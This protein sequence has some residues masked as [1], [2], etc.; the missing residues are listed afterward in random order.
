MPSEL[1]VLVAAL[2]DLSERRSP[3]ETET[4]QLAQAVFN[5][6]K[7]RATRIQFNRT[8]EHKTTIRDPLPGMDRVEVI[9]KFDPSVEGLVPAKTPWVHRGQ[10]GSTATGKRAI[11][12]TY[13]LEHPEIEDWM[14][15]PLSHDITGVIR[16]ELEHGAQHERGVS[17]AYAPGTGR[18]TA[19]QKDRDW[20]DIEATR[21]YLL[22][23]AEV[24]AW[25]TQAYVVAKR[26]KV[27]V[28]EPINAKLD[29]LTKALRRRAV[30]AGD[31]ESL[32]ADYRKAVTEYIRK[33]YPTAQFRTRSGELVFGQDLTRSWW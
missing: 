6:V 26:T 31:I 16:H 22:D 9:L 27:S 24:E 29:Q 1:R 23:P 5:W 28:T 10:A 19:D 32:V 3:Q 13:R 11:R 30:P 17:V 12:L 15:E 4:R 20:G 7:S 21:A 25:G 2:R 14:L 18:K 33:R 8:G